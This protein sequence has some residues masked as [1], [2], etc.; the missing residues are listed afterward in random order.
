MADAVN[1][2][3]AL[4]RWSE[5]MAEFEADKTKL[6]QEIH[7]LEEEKNKLNRKVKIANT[8]AERVEELVVK[9]EGTLQKAQQAERVVDEAKNQV[10]D[11]TKNASALQEKTTGIND[12]AQENN[13]T[14]EELLDLA[15]KGA[16]SNDFNQYARSYRQRADLYIAGIVGSILVFI[17]ILLIFH[18]LDLPKH[19]S[20]LDVVAYALRKVAI[21]APFI[22]LIYLFTH[23]HNDARK[24]EQEYRFKTAV[25]LSLKANKELISELYTRE[26]S[27]KDNENKLQ[28]P[29]AEFAKDIVQN[30]I[31]RPPKIGSN[32]EDETYDDAPNL[33]YFATRQ[34]KRALNLLK[35]LSVVVKNVKP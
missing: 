18:L 23:L 22:Y 1:R 5:I 35:E 27:I 10:D 15:D 14:I 16:L 8:K 21:G 4:R 6:Q 7:E 17:A 20:A 31:Y 33:S 30:N 2:K 28:Y 24:L 9:S 34:T 26:Y 11:L 19:P 12:K 13:S 25:A 3:E 29:I 32:C